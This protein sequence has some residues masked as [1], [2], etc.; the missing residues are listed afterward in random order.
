MQILLAAL[1]VLKAAHLFDAHTGKL[2]SPG[3]LVIDGDRIAQVGGPAPTGAEVLDLGDATLLPG[4]M[5]AHTHLTS[6]SSDSWYKDMVDG[7]LR[8]PAEQAQYAALYARRTLEAGFTTVRDL[9]SNDSIDV[10]LRNAISHGDVTGPRMLVAVN[11]I[12]AT[13]G[14]ADSPYAGDNLTAPGVRQ[15]IC[16]GESECRA[17][18]RWQV[19]Q[20]ADVI[21]FM[22]SGG[23]LSLTDDVDSPQLSQEEMNAIV[24]EAHALKRKAAAH[25]HG[26]LAAKMAIKAGVDS[27][28][29]GTF[30]KDDT[31]AEMKKRSVYL[32]PGPI[33]HVQ[34]EDL[35]KMNYPA[36]IKQKLHAAQLAHPGMLKSA[37][38]MGLRVAF[39]TDAGVGL[40]GHNAEQLPELVEHGMT[41]AQALQAA[42]VVDAELLGVSDKLG[43]L[44]KGKLADVIAV[45]G[46]VLAH[47]EQA[48]EHVAFVMKEGKVIKKVVEAP[49]PKHIALTAAHLFDGKSDTLLDHAT[50]LI[51]GNRI[52]AVG[53]DLQVPADA[54]RIDLGDAT[55]LPGLIDAHVHLTGESSE[56]FAHDFVDQLLR[57]PAE[58][59]LRARTYARRTL[60]AGFTTVRDVGSHDHLAAGLRNAIDKGLADGPRMLV[61]NYGIGTRG[62]HA[63]SAPIPT[64]RAPPRTPETGVCAGADQCREAVRWQLKYGADVIKLMPSGGVLSLSDPVDVPQLTPDETWAIIDEA[65]AWHRKAAAHCHGDAAAKIAIA[66]GVD[67]IEHGSFLKPDTLAEMKVHGTVLIPTMMAV[68][69]VV[70]KA[71]EGKFPEVIAGKALAAGGSLSKTL[72]EAVKLGVTIGCG[73]DS[74]V[75]PHGNNGHELVLMVRAGLSPLA[76]LKAATSVDAELLGISD[77]L[78]TLAPGMLADIVAVPGNP[79]TDISAA[80]RVRF[81]MKD[82]KVFKSP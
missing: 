52:V 68:E 81:V 67:S 63:D 42:T 51:E 56:D 4:L 58:S 59:S 80:E 49:A 48:V 29:H 54:Q 32:M 77:R 6:E 40:H 75:S 71:N 34:P 79:L 7:L 11:A 13:G 3:L 60:E 53:K 82:G 21:K 20:G 14:H 31:L 61:A 43:A 64:D 12:G 41:P 15:G 18:V 2:Q 39:G 47:F 9:G 66:A 16:N 27:I 76:A 45:P 62:G 72:G 1:L 10:G 38:R 37:I 22:P 8:S 5:D 33:G 44:D 35:G 69:T 17:A 19:K 30:L 50:V 36:A 78:G 23:V 24:Q 26:D 57:T 70:R 25:C 74:A 65:H 73:T 55:L 46:D 28:E